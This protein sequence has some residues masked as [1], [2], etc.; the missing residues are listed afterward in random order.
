MALIIAVAGGICA[1]LP[2]PGLFIGLGL[3]IFSVA[4]GVIAY[5]RRADPGGARLAGAAG[6]AIG[7]IAVVLC[8]ARYAVIFAALRKLERL[9]G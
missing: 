1:A 2:A 9:F 5:Q 3:A 8:A 4:T 6:I 7:S